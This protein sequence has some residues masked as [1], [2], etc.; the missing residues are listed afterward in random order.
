MF[1]DLKSLSITMLLMLLTAAPAMAQQKFTPPATGRM[2]FNFNPDWKFIKQD[3]ADSEKPEFDDSKWTTVSTPHTYNETDTFDGFITRG[4]EVEQYMGPSRYRKHFKLPQVAPGSRVILEFE[5]MRQA[6]KFWVNGKE[7]GMHEDGVT[8]VGVDI[9]DAVQF[10]GK[11]N[12]LTVRVT[13][14]NNYKE[15]ATG[16]TYQWGSK[17]FNPSYGGLNRNVRLY[18]LPPI[19]QTLPLL[20]NLKTTGV[21]VYASDFDIPGKKATIGV[22]SQVRNGSTNQ[23]A[24]ELSA[25]VVDRAGNVVGK[26][27]GE[28]YDM[29]NGETTVMKASGELSNLR[30]WSP[31]DPYLYDVYT[32]LSVGG[33]PVDVEKIT[34]GF[35]KTEFKGGVGTGGVY[36]N[37]KFTYLKGYA[38]RTVN[39]WAAIGAAYPNWMHDF[40]MKLMADSNANY[41]R[42]M[43]I[44]PRKQEVDSADKFGIVQVCPAGDKEANP[45]IQRQWEQRVEVMRATIVYFRNSPSIL[46]WEAGNNGIPASR[47][48]QMV[49]IRKEL[50]PNGGRAMGCRSLPASQGENVRNPADNDPGAQGGSKDQNLNVAE[51]FGVM[52]GQDP[53]TDR[54]TEPQA[55]FRSFSRERRDEAP[56]IETED[57]RDEVLRRNWDKFSPPNFGF[58]KGPNDTYN[59]D[60]ESFCLAAAGRYNDFWSRRITNT[61]PMK[62]NWSGYASIIWADSNQHGR[63]PDSAVCRTS[64]KVDAV[65]IP[66][67]AFYV[68]QVMQNEKP[69]VHIIGHWTY[70]ADTT[71]TMYVAA[72]HID[73]VEL[74]INGKSIGK[75]TQPDDGFIYAFPDVK[76]QPG[77]ITAKAYANGQ[78]VAEHTLKTAGAAKSIKLTPYTGPEGFLAHGGD[79]AFFDVEVVDAEGN[80]CPT[81]EGRVDFELS[82]PAIWRGGVNEWKPKST[83]NTYLDT[84]CGINRVFIRSTLQPGEIKLTAK[85]EGLTPATVTIE[86]KPFEVKDGLATKMPQEMP[87]PAK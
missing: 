20:H 42:W 68:Y 24:I 78:V 27:N 70:P 37:D 26:I 85:R 71:K 23:A 46:F 77:T 49:D 67:E 74:L 57:F 73:S 58:K 15:E 56:I 55:M 82:G 62:S 36:I 19:H 65:R 45:T 25:T 48:Q 30:F 51:Y 13:N 63:L 21:Y 12:V 1:S 17:D 34:T 47:M 8:A 35:R 43:H 18:I 54:L 52:V 2:V 16:Q 40:D 7:L 66:K 53:R 22:D 81:D 5:G 59:H 38:Q 60:V 86:A 32:I 31:E 50:D 4:G 14:E 79:V 3:V 29:V 41:V 44:A 61:D 6:A 87:Y 28:T 76:F 11:E 83:N 84:E 72:N 9:T 69:D 64:G 80:R 75:D 10:G 39:E 33:K